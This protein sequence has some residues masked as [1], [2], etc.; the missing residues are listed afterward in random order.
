[1]ALYE[2]E[3]QLT[4]EQCSDNVFCHQ[5]IGQANQSD[6]APDLSLAAHHKVVATKA[7]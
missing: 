3:T 5:A 4:L 2:S 6:V 1:V 7:E